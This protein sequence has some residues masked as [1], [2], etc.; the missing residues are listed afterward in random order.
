VFG[1]RTIFEVNLNTL[2][3]LNGTSW[4]TEYLQNTR[5]EH[6]LVQL[7]SYCKN[8][9]SDLVSL[10]VTRGAGCVRWKDHIRSEPEHPGS[11]QRQLVAHGISAAY[12]IRALYGPAAVSIIFFMSCDF[13]LKNGF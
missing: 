9:N 6:S 11:A 10:F 12:S 3:V 1:G 7:P 2:E 8:C 13:D 5:S 4:H